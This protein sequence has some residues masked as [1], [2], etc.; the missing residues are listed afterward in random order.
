MQHTNPKQRTTRP[1]KT[2]SKQHESVDTLPRVGRTL[3]VKSTTT[4]TNLDESEFSSFDGLTSRF[5][6]KAGNSFFLTFNTA[7]A[8]QKAFNVLNNNSNFRVKFSYYRTFFTIKGLTTDS[9]YNQV[10]KE[11]SDY[12]K[13]KSGAT[14]L[15]CKFYRKDNNYIG[16]GDLTVDTLDGMNTLLNKD[17]GVK[18]F[19]FGNFTGT[20]YR[21]NNTN[22]KRPQAQSRS[23][24]V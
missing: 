17:G 9:D 19:S 16:C 8:A 7:D 4:N 3:L 13:E 20:F 6:T 24:D 5:K 2:E 11:L 1:R 21:Y 22:T 14:V 10:K 12:V 15:Y 23:A 18:D